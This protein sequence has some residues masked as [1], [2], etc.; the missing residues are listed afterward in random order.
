MSQSKYGLRP[1]KQL[2]YALVP[3]GK[4]LQ[5]PL[6]GFSP[7]PKSPRVI[8]DDPL[9]EEAVEFAEL[10]QLL[11]QAKLIRKQSLRRSIAT[12]ADAP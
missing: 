7:E 2:D 8:V 3:E 12:G 1:C 6:F 9:H 10:K 4:Q 11:E 5:F